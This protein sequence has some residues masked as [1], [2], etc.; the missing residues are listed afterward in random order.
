MLRAFRRLELRGSGGNPMSYINLSKTR[1]DAFEIK[2]FNMICKA[3]T[4]SSWNF[5]DGSD[6]V[7]CCK[8]KTQSGKAWVIRTHEDLEEALPETAEM[9]TEIELFREDDDKILLL[10]YKEFDGRWRCD[11]DFQEKLEKVF[12]A[13]GV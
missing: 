9:P 12:N 4:F 2:L 11:S 3:K 6:L 10:L 13:F 1:C 7:H 8:A 5:Q